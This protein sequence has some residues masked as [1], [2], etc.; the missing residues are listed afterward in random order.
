MFIF[1]IYAICLVAT[2]CL[3]V[4]KS[5]GATEDLSARWITIGLWLCMGTDIQSKGCDWSLPSSILWF[6]LI[7]RL[8]Y[9]MGHLL[10]N[11]ISTRKLWYVMTEA[12]T[13]EFSD[14]H[15]VIII[16]DTIFT[17]RFTILY[18][19]VACDFM[20]YLLVIHDIYMLSL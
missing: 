8:C 11:I 7:R 9:V 18:F 20:I 6:S 12:F 5:V 13:Y 2:L 3:W 14:M 4:W 17:V 19:Y 15:V 1:E 16:H 10:R